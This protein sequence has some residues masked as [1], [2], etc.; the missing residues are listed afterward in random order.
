MT[1]FEEGCSIIIDGPAYL[2]LM[3]GALRVLGVEYRGKG[4]IVVR[5]GRSVPIEFLEDSEVE[6]LSASNPSFERIDEV[7]PSE[8]FEALRIVS[9]TDPVNVLVLGSVDVGKSTFALMCA[10]HILSTG[11][12][13]VAIVDGDLGQTDIG[14]PGALSYTLLDKPT[15]DLF[16]F[17]FEEAVFI[18][19]LTPYQMVDKIVESLTYLKSRASSRSKA[20][21]V[22]TDGWFTVE[23]IPYKA[24]IV[25]RLRPKATVVID[26]D[27]DLSLIEDIAKSSGSTVIRIPPPKYIRGKSRSDRKGRRELCYRK[28]FIDP[29]V[30]KIPV[31]WVRFIDFPIGLGATLQVDKLREISANLGLECIYGERTGSTLYIIAR[32]DSEDYM[33]IEYGG[34]KGIVIPDRLIKGLLM[35]VYDQTEVFRGLAILKSIFMEGDR[36]V[37]E[38]ITSYRGSIGCLKPGSVRLDENFK[39]V[40]KFKSIL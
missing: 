29:T 12:K 10:N 26:G 4:K 24:R 19:S 7:F 38:L 8:W 28:Y 27:I 25:E 22:N 20:I 32:I 9:K 40:A 18:G 13:P 14:P 30:R 39:E 33:E 6:V 15:V 5:E 35:G 21:I 34:V 17:R 31:T 37:V 2:K 23:A 1:R 11:V 16:N 36:G 3:S